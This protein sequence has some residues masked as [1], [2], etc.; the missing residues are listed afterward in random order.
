MINF[1]SPAHRTLSDIYPTVEDFLKDY[2]S[3]GIP[4]TI[5][6]DS[7]K[8]LYYLLQARY[9]SWQIASDSSDIFSM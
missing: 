1:I 3:N 5:T 4:T 6:E 2:K 7:A 8:T 9:G